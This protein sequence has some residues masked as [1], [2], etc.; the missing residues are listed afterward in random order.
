MEAPTE[1]TA[2][3]GFAASGGDSERELHA[4]VV[5]DIPSENI[6]ASTAPNAI[7]EAPFARIMSEY[8]FDLLSARVWPQLQQA[9]GQRRAARKARNFGRS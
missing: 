8:P 2:G 4:A 5:N 6:E 3:T 7:T 1:V 9:A